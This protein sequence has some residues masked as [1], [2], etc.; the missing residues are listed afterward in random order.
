MRGRC[1]NA[2]AL[3]LASARTGLAAERR[4]AVFDFRSIDTSLEGATNGPR[5]NA[6]SRLA[7]ST[8]G[9]CDVSLVG[10]LGARFSASDWAQQVSNFIRNM[11]IVARDANTGPRISG[12][13][14]DVRSKR[15][16]SPSRAFDGLLRDE[17]FL[18]QG[19]GA[20]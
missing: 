4:I 18:V 15:N 2:I 12:N 9:N 14:V 13:S 1:K 19:R 11:K 8:S 17:L 6:L 7:M 10:E 5:A 16:T 20:F 3:S